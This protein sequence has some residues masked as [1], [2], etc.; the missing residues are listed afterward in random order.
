MQCY[1]TVKIKDIMKFAGTWM[2]LEIIL[3][4]VTQI[5]KDKCGKY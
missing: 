3:S 4:E 1:S 2:R 5:Q